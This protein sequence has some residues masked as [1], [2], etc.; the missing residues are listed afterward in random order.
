M[1][2]LRFFPFLACVSLLLCSFSSTFVHAQSDNEAPLH[3]TNHVKRYGSGA[4]YWMS[5]ITRQGKVVYGTNSSYVVWRNV[6]DYGAKGDGITDDTDAINNATY[7]G[8]RCAYPCDSQTTAPAIVYFPPGTYAISR[9]LVM[10]YYTQFIGDANNLPVIM[11]LPNFYGIALLDSDPYLAFGFS[12]WANQNNMWRQVRNFVLDIRQIP[13]GVAHCLHWQVAQGT[14][15]QNIVFEMTEGGDDN[16]QMGIFMDNGSALYLEDL[17]FNG[18]SVGFFSGNQQ[19]TC[20]NL[21]FNNCQ[22]AIYQ[23]WNWLFSYKDV[24]INN[25]RV[26]INMTQGGDVP[27][28]GSITLQDATMNNVQIGVS[29]TFST[30]S[31][32]ASAGTFIL[33]NVNFVDTP[34]AV[35]HSPSNNILLAGNQRVA[36]WAQGRVYTAYE[37]SYEENNLTCYGPAANYARVQQTVDPAPKSPS[38]LAPDGSFFTRSRPQYEGV[39]VESFKSIKTY[40]CAGDGVTDDTACVQSFLD[41]ITP[42]QI[43]YIDYGAYVIRDTINFPIPIRVQGELWPY[44]MVDGTAPKFSDKNNPQAAF[45]VGEP[46]QVGD[47]ELVEII[48]QTLGAAPGAIMMEWNLAQ[49][50]QGSAGIWDV[51]WRIGGTNGTELQSTNCAKTPNTPTTPN[52]ECYGA[53][54]LLHI[55]RSASMY[56]SNNWGWVSDHEMDL[57]DHNQINIYNG[58]GVLVESQGPVWMVGTS[59]EHSMLYNYQISGAKEIYISALQTETAYM[60]N[61]PDALAPYPPMSNWNDPTFSDCFTSNCPKTWGCRIFN[62]TYIFVYGAGMYS[63]FNN[64]DSGCLATT[65]CQQK[66]VSV[67]QSQGIYMYAVNTVGSLNLV[68]VDEVDLV[69][70][71]SNGNGFADTVAI[72]EYP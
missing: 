59:F 53:F 41:S 68:T 22:T 46:G 45:R 67:E 62:S 42:D 37:S 54:L 27:T 39:P 57:L 61:N 40:G 60:Q 35:Q 52:P 48:F 11:G 36:S 30:N 32:P 58:R 18:G 14:S 28:T 47:I 69:P 50:S 6:M 16:E 8:N 25:A 24:V 63:F 21:T 44:F 38:L 34:I 31:T 4:P 71:I 55:T 23:N 3:T 13:P 9:P 70:S 43:A 20:R 26:G 72:F 7:D 17:I 29:T 15:L 19:F 66:M 2:R 12:W 1:A 51:H 5:E 49:S 10:L 64:Y 65:N 33:D 56:M